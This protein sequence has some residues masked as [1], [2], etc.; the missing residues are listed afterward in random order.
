MNFLQLAAFAYQLRA[1]TEDLEPITVEPLGDGTYQITDGRHRAIA[2]L[3]AGRPDVLAIVQGE[4]D[5]DAAQDPSRQ[6]HDDY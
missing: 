1:T 6:G 2:A 5:P 3:I 4:R